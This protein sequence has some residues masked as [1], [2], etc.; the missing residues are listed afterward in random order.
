MEFKEQLNN[1]FKELRKAGYIAKQNFSCCTG[2]ACYELGEYFSKKGIP[3]GKERKS[4]YYH[5]QD[6]LDIEKGFIYLGWSGN[7]TEIVTIA[8]KVGL[9]V[10]WDGNEKLKIKVFI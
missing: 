2:C 7:G 4:V 3:E 1:L 9:K 6:T 10:D 5:H 8:K